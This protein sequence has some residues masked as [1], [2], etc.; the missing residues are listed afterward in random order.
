VGIGGQYGKDLIQIGTEQD[1]TGGQ[2]VYSAWY[3]TL[4]NE[5]ITINSIVVS[6]DDRIEAS[7]VLV[8]N[9]SNLWAVSLSDLTSAQSFSLNISYASNR[10]SAEWIVER[11]DVNSRISRLANFGTVTFTGCAADFGSVGSITSFASAKV[12]MVS[13]SNSQQTAQLTDVSSLSGDGSGFTV[14]YLGS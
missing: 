9:A 1:S 5:A 10:T 3:E 4:P 12:V 2:A 6:P 11:P 13:Q 8:D 7:V 14:N